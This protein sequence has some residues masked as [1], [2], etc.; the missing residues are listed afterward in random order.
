[1]KIPPL[2]NVAFGL[3][4]VLPHRRELLV[5]GRPIKLGGRA[6]DVLV[7]LMESPG[8]VVDGHALIRR[9]W[10]GRI[11]D[12]NNL[13]AQISALR[14]AFGAERDLIR[15]VP[16]RGYQFTGEV[17]ALLPSPDERA[18]T[19]VDEPQ[20][21]L[22]PT[23]LPGAFSELIG[24]DDDVRV[25]LGFAA[26]HRLATL[27][28]AGGIGKT[29][30]GLEVA[31]QL[32]RRFADGVWVAELA[33]LSDASLVPVTVAA[34]VGLEFPDGAV[35]PD[36][37]AVAL[38]GKELL[39][40]LDNCE[41]VIA[42]AAA[43]AEA[44]VRANP[45]VHVIATSQEPLNSEGEWVYPVPPLAVPTT[46]GDE[47]GDPSGYGAVRL[48]FERARAAIP[49]FSPDPQTTEVVTAICRRLD[50]I[51][52]AIELAAARAATV[53]I[54]ELA[55]RL[56]DRFHLLTGGRRT[57]LPRHQ[58]LRATLSWSHE[59]LA[60]P[61]RLILR[62]LGVFAG[63]FGLEAASAVVASAEIT[64]SAIVNGLSNLAAK[65]LVTANFV[66]TIGRYRLLETTRSYAL[67]K[68]AESGEMAMVSRCHAKYYCDFFER[69]EVELKGH[70]SGEWL[71][72]FG[73]Q[74]DNL[75]A[76]LDWAF[77]PYG[78]A[79][80]GIALT[81]AA[82]PL[83]MHLSL[84][85]E[86]RSRVEQALAALGAG[87]SVE[88]RHEMKLHAALAASSI[89][90]RGP[91]A[92]LGAV[93][94]KSLKFA[95]RL[96]DTEYQLRSL[97][98]LWLLNSS[99]SARVS[100]EMATRFHA[101]AA[102]QP[103]QTEAV[104]GEGM[105]GT[106]QLWLGELTAARYHLERALAHPLVPHYRAQIIRYQIGPDVTVRTTLAR[107]L[108]L[109]GFSDQALPLAERAVE[110]AS[111][112]N[113][114]TPL[115]TALTFAACQIALWVGDLDRADHY[116]KML[117][118]LAD[119][120]ALS[121][122]RVYARSYAALLVMRRGNLGHGS[123]LLRATFDE[124]NKTKS[125]TTYLTIL[126]DI[127]EGLGH[128]GQIV[129]GLSAVDQAIARAEH[130][131]ERALIP[132]F[133]RVKGDLVL[134]RGGSGDAAAAENVLRQALDR[135]RQQ[136][137][138]AWELRAVT[139]LARLLRDRGN[140]AEGVSLMRPVYGRFTEG[141]NTTDLKAARA[142]IGTAT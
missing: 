20:W 74:I 128:V 114:A 48:F 73:R 70:P 47:K 67:E 139:S 28:G 109:Q 140:S 33:P 11:V 134:L 112:T 92:E 5:D 100:L 56:D 103:D 131:G 34:A 69:G 107:V 63:S 27:T 18:G 43:M 12:E 60:E 23:N 86:C 120:Y 38:A 108:W 104:I 58:T 4:Q 83:W 138:L 132:E 126:G 99:D 17:R 41:H 125:L 31:R 45:G 14:L 111:A 51:P 95:E 65:S 54:E 21:D 110:D 32:L 127:A 16:G 71:A 37:V 50:G 91:V 55:A 137:T 10:P 2:T 59:L 130:I 129:D 81:A 96:E 98:G 62:R 39:V 35:T 89:Y 49:Y 29:K 142:H 9:V 88:A 76:A 82:E 30:L 79:S 44:L 80:I 24:R 102:E 123:H 78:D 57:A 6:F 119:R 105:I 66:S 8:A 85:E 90:A 40:V 87:A 106:S 136:G 61:E 64:R 97:W 13:R 52:L 133:L 7:A 93:W 124:L 77:S 36:R 46:G 68:L 84:I 113:H 141:F 101:L 15:T 75:R 19:G 122:W 117:I 94:A 22:P 72:D 121:Y 42:A 3:F 1:M 26:A 53:G 116:V 118:D 25:L 115:C 135:A